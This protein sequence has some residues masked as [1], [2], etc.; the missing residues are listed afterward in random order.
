L[1]ASLRTICW[2]TS[3]TFS[4]STRC[5]C[6]AP[7]SA[8]TAEAARA[9]SMHRAVCSASFSGYARKNES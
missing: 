2:L 9:L 5:T 4:E 6:A 1:S 7:F 8:A 3:A